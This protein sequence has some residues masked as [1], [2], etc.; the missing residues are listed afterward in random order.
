MYSANRANANQTSRQ[1]RPLWCD[2]GPHEHGSSAAL[3]DCIICVFG[4]CPVHLVC[5]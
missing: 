2:C 5:P 1:L 4:V 3:C